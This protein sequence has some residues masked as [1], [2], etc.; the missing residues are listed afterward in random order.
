MSKRRVMYLRNGDMPVGCVVISIAKNKKTLRY[1][2]ST[3]HPIDTIDKATNKRIKIDKAHSRQL[4]LGRLLECPYRIKV[5][6]VDAMSMT[7]ITA[8]VLASIYKNSELPSRTRK[9]AKSWFNNFIE[10]KTETKTKA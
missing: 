2:V 8:L 1:Q 10:D 5:D 6:N 4:A 7:D 9:A 3:I